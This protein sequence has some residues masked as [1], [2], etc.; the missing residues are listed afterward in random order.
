MNISQGLLSFIL[1]AK[2]V[3]NVSESVRYEPPFVLTLLIFILNA[4]MSHESR[5]LIL[6][7][8]PHGRQPHIE[9][10]FIVSV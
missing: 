8:F 5:A 6:H 10:L 7:A 4:V 1:P 9:R 2:E 3:D